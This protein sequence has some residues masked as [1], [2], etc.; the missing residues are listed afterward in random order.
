M[1]GFKSTAPVIA[2]N[3]F[4]TPM[5]MDFATPREFPLATPMEIDFPCLIEHNLT[6]PEFDS[7]VP[8]EIDFNDPG[9]NLAT[10]DSGSFSGIDLGQLIKLSIGNIEDYL[11][12]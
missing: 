4:A 9:F 7:V 1:E 5:D 10:Q 2:P 12:I 6:F 3:T 8:M 11:N